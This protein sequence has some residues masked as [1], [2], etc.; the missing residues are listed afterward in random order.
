MES[1][2]AYLVLPGYGDSGPAHWQTLWEAGRPFFRRVPQKEWL[3]PVRT[4][5]VDTLEQAVA[6][7]EPGIVL[8]AHSLACL[9]VAHWSASAPK[10]SLEKIRAAFLVAPVD[11]AG[12]VF[13][14]GAVGFAPVPMHPLPFPALVVA[15]S[16]DPYAGPGYSRACAKAWG[17]RLAEISAKGHI[18]SDSG[19]GSWPE[20]ISLLESITGP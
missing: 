16:D 20:G 14:E 17:A 11:P 6:G 7:V 12:P 15:S 1:K 2:L 3:H 4:D 10:R 18:N 13:P 19:L 5:W 9:L 8:V